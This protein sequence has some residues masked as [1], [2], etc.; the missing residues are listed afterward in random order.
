MGNRPTAPGWF[1]RRG[2][3][4]LPLLRR[5][6]TQIVP[7]VYSQMERQ[8]TVPIGSLPDFWNVPGHKPTLL[9]Q[10]GMK[11]G[12]GYIRV[13]TQE[14]NVAPQEV[15]M[16]SLSVDEVYIDRTSGK[17]TDR[18]ALKKM[19]VY[20]RKGDIVVVGS[21]SRFARNIRNLLKLAEK[22]KVGEKRRDRSLPKEGYRYQ[23]AH[24][25][26]HAHSIWGRIPTGTGMHPT[27]PAGG[28]R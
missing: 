17:D 23:H 6:V 9:G 22:L 19:L 26:I 13:S 2:D 1:Y 21:I 10:R 15:L 14:Q 4:G 8:K 20:V 16:E 7:L 25:E 24:R 12:I 18:P 27:S 5:V 3:R 11:M 28:S